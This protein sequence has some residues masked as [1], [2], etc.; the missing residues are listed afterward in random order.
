MKKTRCSICK[1]ELEIPVDESWEALCRGCI[2]RDV[3]EMK[4]SY[5][6][7]FVEDYDKGILGEER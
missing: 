5:N 6:N 2:A 1:N 4:R 3:K 7:L